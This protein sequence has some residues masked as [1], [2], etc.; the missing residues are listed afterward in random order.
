MTIVKAL[1]MMLL[2]GGVIGFLLGFALAGFLAF[3][4][5]R[6]ASAPADHRRHKARR[7]IAYLFIFLSFLKSKDTTIN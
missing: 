7:I 5:L 4:F 3:L 1:I 6:W 2:L